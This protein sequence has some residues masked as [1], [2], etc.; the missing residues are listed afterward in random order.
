MIDLSILRDACCELFSV[1]RDFNATG[2]QGTGPGGDK[3]TVN[4]EMLQVIR[5]T[6]FVR[7]ITMGHENLL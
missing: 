4:K 5:Q 3:L 1:F 7:L 2:M 6:Y